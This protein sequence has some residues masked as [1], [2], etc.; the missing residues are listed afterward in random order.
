MKDS[1][2]KYRAGLGRALWIQN[3]LCESHL[4][5]TLDSSQ[6]LNRERD[7]SSECGASI[8]EF[9]I[10]SV[11]YF[12]L[13]FGVIQLG[14]GLYTYNF[15]SE[16]AREA[17]RYAV[18]RGSQSCTV[19]PTFPNCNLL[20]TSTG[21]PLKTYVQSLHYPGSNAGNLTVTATWWEPTT[22]NG[23]KSWTTPCTGATDGSGN[24]CN[25]AGNMVQVVVTDNYK[26]A[27]PF[28]PN[29][30]LPV[31]SVSELMIDE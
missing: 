9:A 13:F 10:A 2:V 30:T 24:A 26:L 28:V 31:S 14:M 12:S 16:A 18:V 8:I 17:S 27:I 25:L 11:I 3:L 23:N 15:V 21:N 1:T 19:S 6:R 4:R 29:I 7:I 22:T 5:C 20:P